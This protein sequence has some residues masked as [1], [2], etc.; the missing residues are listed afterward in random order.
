MTDERHAAQ[1]WLFVDEEDLEQPLTRRDRA[2]IARLGPEV[3]VRRLWLRAFAALAAAS[4]GLLVGL[5]DD[6]PV[7]ATIAYCAAFVLFAVAAGQAFR[8]RRIQCAGDVEVVFRD[9]VLDPAQPRRRPLPPASRPVAQG[10][11]LR[12]GRHARC[13]FD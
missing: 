1:P 6:A 10:A 8:A 7:A 11:N 9:D 4:A 2:D 12:G 13:D 5:N 3:L